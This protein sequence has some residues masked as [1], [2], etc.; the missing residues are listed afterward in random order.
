MNAEAMSHALSRALNLIS[1]QGSRVGVS[2]SVCLPPIQ[3][4]IISPFFSRLVPI[5]PSI[6][7]Q[8]S[9]PFS[10]GFFASFFSFLFFPFL[11]SCVFPSPP[12]WATSI[13]HH[14]KRQTL[15]HLRLPHPVVFLLSL[16]LFCCKGLTCLD[17]R[18]S[19][20]ID[21]W[22]LRGIL[23]SKSDQAIPYHR[24]PITLPSFFSPKVF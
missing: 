8:R 13:T 10:F 2:L 12:C 15:L 3:G 5:I 20:A 18:P 19:I 17:F 24:Q 14:Q 9:N 1:L 21:N 23:W 16:P 4:S 22:S 11:H 6:P 7:R